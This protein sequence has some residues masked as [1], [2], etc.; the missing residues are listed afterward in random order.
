MEGII[1][2]ISQ[3]IYNYLDLFPDGVKEFLEN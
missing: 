1:L 3:G 2:L